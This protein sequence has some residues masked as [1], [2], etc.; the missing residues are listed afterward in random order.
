LVDFLVN[1]PQPNVSSPMKN[2]RSCIIIICTAVLS[3]SPLISE[4]AKRGRVVRHGTHFHRN[5][6][7]LHAGHLIRRVMRPALLVRP[8]FCP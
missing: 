8:D 4:A 1:A 5:T 7:V 2:L 3:L 6:V